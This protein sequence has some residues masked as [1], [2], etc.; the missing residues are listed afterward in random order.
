MYWKKFD[1]NRV[2]DVELN[3]C[4]FVSFNSRSTNSF[5][6]TTSSNVVIRWDSYR[7]S[8]VS[9]PGRFLVVL[10]STKNNRTTT[11]VTCFIL[12]IAGERRYI[13]KQFSFSQ[14]YLPSD[15]IQRIWRLDERLKN[16]RKRRETVELVIFL[17]KNHD[18][19]RPCVSR[20]AVFRSPDTT[21]DV[22]L[23]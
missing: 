3:S 7:S 22:R 1:I 19:T 5:Q 16:R 12:Y 18:M 14:D 9:L 23:E 13:E 20:F 21:V 8:C 10:S 11:N 6:P 17:S 2:F 4:H 15:P